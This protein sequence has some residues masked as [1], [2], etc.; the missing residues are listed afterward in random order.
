[1]KSSR[2]LPQRRDGS[3]LLTAVIFAFAIAAAAASYISLTIHSMRSSDRSYYYNYATN[4]AEAGL[5]RAMYLLNTS[6]GQGWTNPTANERV[7]AETSV[8]VQGE[9]GATA[10]YRA[11]ITGANTNAP[12]IVAEGKV[13]PPNGTPIRK[14]IEVKLG[15]TSRYNL[16]VVARKG[17]DLNGR[18]VT[19]NSFSS[20]ATFAATGSYQ[21]SPTHANYN[22]TVATTFIADVDA[23]IDIGTASIH[24][25]VT[26]SDIKNL[27]IS[28]GEIRGGPGPIANPHPN[29]PNVDLDL[30][31]QDFVEDVK[32]LLLPPSGNAVPT[33]SSVTL[34]SGTYNFAGTWNNRSAVIDGDVTLH[35]QGEFKM[36]GNSKITVNEGSSLKLVLHGDG[37]VTGNAFINNS[38]NP[39]NLMIIGAVSNPGDTALRSFK[40]AGNGGVAGILDMPNYQVHLGGGG[41]DVVD[42]SGALIAYSI[43]MNGKFQ[44]HYDEDL[45]NLDGEGKLRVTSWRELKAP[46][47]KS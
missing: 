41:N 9:R 14:Q 20:S 5:E 33:G 18:N 15:K 36:A 35:I 6:D 8:S 17:I 2:F 46:D 31:T 21:Y 42:V 40:V 4:L 1:M 3:V 29:N 34:T 7:L 24:G 26:T 19:I 16:G 38:H 43:K 25:A 11:W 23:T 10:S 30:I 37:Q 12:T 44:F 22:G 27:N 47:F 32:P 39:A 13:T 28:K 45:A